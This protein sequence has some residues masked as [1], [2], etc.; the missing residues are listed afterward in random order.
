[1]EPLGGIGFPSPITTQSGI[2]PYTEALTRSPRSVVAALILLAGVP[3]GLVTAILSGDGAENVIHIALGASF[4]LLAFAVFDFKLPMWMNWTGCITTGMLAAIFL[5]QGA[6]DLMHSVPL[7]HLA[8]EVL[9]QRLE[10]LLGYAFLLWCVAM[11][12]SDSTG[13]TK[14]LGVVV[15]TAILLIEIYSIVTT[16]SGG[17]APGFLKLFYLPL[18][19]W[20]LL[21]GLKPR[22]RST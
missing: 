5:L 20:L 18:F 8:Y 12:F 21:E 7:Q 9:G 1:M 13:T 11:L 6:S 22:A 14:V 19:I 2:V 4:L 10:K 16:Y 17:E 3:L 15:L